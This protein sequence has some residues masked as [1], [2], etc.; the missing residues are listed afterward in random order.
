MEEVSR[1]VFWQPLSI[2]NAYLVGERGGPWALIDTGLHA[3]HL[4][5]ITAT[6]AR[7]FGENVRPEA[8]YLTHGHFD[9]VGAVRELAALWD[10][11]V[12]AHRL[13]MPYLRGQSAY[14][15]PDP[16]VGGFMANLSRFFPKGSAP[17]DHHLQE[18][19][20]GDLPGL[21]GWE[22]HFTPGHSPGHVA[23]F[24]PEDRT[25]IAGDAF[26]T[27][28]QDSA[29][30]MLTQKQEV[31]RPPNY[32]TPDWELARRSVVHLAGLNPLTAACGHGVPMS[33]PDMARQLHALADGFPVP[34]HGR[35]VR[36]PA[37]M[38]ETGVVTLPPPCPDPVPTVATGVGVTVLALAL[39]SLVR[40]RGR[41]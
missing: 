6:A 5:P 12:Y 29:T 36:E 25:L 26:V 39:A 24:R 3:G 41:G 22:A 38:D 33:G 35:Y 16:T 40:N 34:H 21:P 2:T 9:H 18:M 14:P 1:G 15:P 17:L 37:V 13:E 4:K 19:P 28:N 32:Y 11:P 7:L 8:I 20:T 30:A 27:V 10:V 31:Y 23:F